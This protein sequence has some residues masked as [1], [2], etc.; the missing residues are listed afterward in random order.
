MDHIQTEIDAQTTNMGTILTQITDN[1]T[2]TTQMNSI[3]SLLIELSAAANDIQGLAQARRRKRNTGTSCAHL[4]SLIKADATVMHKIDKILSKLDEIGR[5]GKESVDRFVHDAKQTYTTHKASSSA[6]KSSLEAIY[7][8]DCTTTT[9][10][11]TPEL[12]HTTT[13]F[14]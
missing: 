14:R 13:S 1:A 11:S 4:Q 5:T 10:A 9:P 2:L 8:Q 3:Q 7:N 12:L 6:S